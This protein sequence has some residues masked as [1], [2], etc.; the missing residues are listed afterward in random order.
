MP[1]TTGI[2]R[3]LSPA[4][5]TG[6]PFRSGDRMAERYV[7]KDAI[8]IGPLGYVFRASDEQQGI[9]VAVK[10]IH[11]RF[12]QT[13]E[14]REAFS[15]AVEPAR[16]F[17]QPSLA[18]V[19]DLGVEQGWPFV[20]YSFLDGLTLRRMIDSRLAKGQTFTLEEVEPFLGQLAAALEAT[21]ALGAHADLK[22]ENV[23]ILPDMLRV[24]DWGVAR[25]LPRLPFVQAQ[26]Q[27]SAHRY[28]APEL[29]SGGEVDSRADLYSL[30]VLVGEMLT[31]LTPDDD[32]PELRLTSSEL[33]EALEGF[34]RRALNERPEARFR[35]VRELYEEF[36]ALLAPASARVPVSA[37]ISEMA[38]HVPPAEPDAVVEDLEPISEP[39][40]GGAETASTSTPAPAGDAPVA[41]A[42]SASSQPIAAAALPRFEGQSWETPRHTR[43][44]VALDPP[45]WTGTAQA[46]NEAS[47]PEGERWSSVKLWDAESDS[48]GEAPGA[49]P[50]AAA[51]ATG[52]ELPVNTQPARALVGTPRPP[53]GMLDPSEEEAERAVAGLTEIGGGPEVVV[54][55]E[56]ND[57]PL[58]AEALGVDLVVDG[59]EPVPEVVSS[60]P[61]PVPGPEPVDTP[62]PAPVTAAP[63][64]PPVREVPRLVPESRPWNSEPRPAPFRR[65]SP[66]L[67]PR[68]APA[69][70]PAAS[71]AEAP[72]VAARS[73]L[74]P[75]P[76]IPPLRSA[77][78]RLSSVEPSTAGAPAPTP[79]SVVPEPSPT[80]QEKVVVPPPPPEALAVTPAVGP[81]VAPARGAGSWSPAE[82]LAQVIAEIQTEER[83][84][85]LPRGAAW[86]PVPLD[87]TQPISTDEVAARLAAESYR[88]ATASFAAPDDEDLPAW[89]HEAGRAG[90]RMA[91][92]TAVG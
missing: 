34:Y 66:V 76:S 16:R 40:A 41:E 85:G 87:A 57:E 54:D 88:P 38:K 69:A 60:T 13:A 75:A 83:G 90:M 23:V 12:V 9:D 51:E 45:E 3:K 1:S 73:S 89:R 44:V 25:G 62:R 80:R 42:P 26:K 31:G 39:V 86:E 53:G 63:P 70:A 21:H 46:S 8:G 52:P 84:A 77:V 15:R 30:G 7:V 92:L 14:E 10:M 33:P 91:L 36:V 58:L 20:T 11:P 49:R 4:L 37:P 74:P 22:P 35:S 29:V 17:M 27:K 48:E 56:G 61:T 79:I 71:L 5:L 59:D 19:H 82:L 43:E 24:V 18:R 64:P 32:I 72:T 50:A 47:R 78:P 55:A 67:H 28:L 81:A 68:P 6:A 65:E 2:R